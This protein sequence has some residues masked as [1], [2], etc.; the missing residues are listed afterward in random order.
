MQLDL[1]GDGDFGDTGEYDD[2]RTHNDF[3]ELI[4]RDT[5]DNGTDD[6]TLVYN[7][8]GQLTD[9]DEHYKYVYDAF[10]RLRFVK[11]TDDP[12]PVIATYRYNG[13]G[14]LISVE[15]NSTVTHNVYDDRWRIVATTSVDLMSILR[16]SS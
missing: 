6:H 16:L 12:N 2:D 8:L 1:T 15:Q 5:D 10:G 4:G 7:K 3:N 14:H 9:D 13:L 11:D